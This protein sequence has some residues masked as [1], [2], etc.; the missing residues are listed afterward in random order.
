MIQGSGSGMDATAISSLESERLEAL[1]KLNILDTGN[2]EVF[3]RI[4]RAV[5]LALDTPICVVSLVDA[6]RQ[7]FKSKVGLCVN[8]TARDVSFCAHAICGSGIMEVP[9]AREDDRFADNPLVTGDPGIR[10]Y[11]GAPLQTKSGFNVGTLCAIDR[12]PRKL[13]AEQRVLLEDLAAVV[14]DHFEL[15]LANQRAQLAESRLMD[16]VQALPDGFV[17]Y[18]ADDRLVL[19]NDRYKAI[20]A[21]SAHAM[22]PGAT[23]ESII[24]AGVQSG[25]YPEAVSQED[26]WIAAR[27]K[28]HRQSDISIEQVLPKDRWLKIEERRTRDGGYVGFRV[29]ITQLKRQ[30]RELA[31]LAWT[32]GLTGVLNR[33]RFYDLANTELK[34]AL[35]SGLPV[36]VVVIDI[37]HFKTI[38]DTRGHSA[39]DAVLIELTRRWTAA[40][41]S[42]DILRRTGGE[43]F[44]ALLPDTDLQGA[45]S[46][47]ERLRECTANEPVDYAGQKIAVTASAGIFQAPRDRADLDRCLSNADKAL[48]QAKRSGR[49]QVSTIA[50]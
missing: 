32:D 24:R 27:L 41:R 37:D 35:R 29:D 44:A 7:W 14:S 45:H 39:G 2:E 34:R 5:S 28:R 9:D 46:V 33:R 4:T 23:F 13:T 16:A 20:Y 26:K 42:H 31:R 8:E 21:E 1:A 12:R 50:A 10:F 47:A 19:C 40:L 25:Q 17:L 18:D 43:E 3:D 49:N 6:D 48:Y 11:A 30:Q 38:N 15:R 36:S 22:V